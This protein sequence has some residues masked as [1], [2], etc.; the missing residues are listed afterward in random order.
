MIGWVLAFGLLLCGL[1][2]ILFVLS[3]IKDLWTQSFLPLFYDAAQ[4]QNSIRRQHFAAHIEHEIWRL[5]LKEEWKDYRFAELEAEVDAEGRHTVFGILPFFKRTR[6]G[7]R[8]EK[9]LSKALRKSQERLILV[10]GEPGSGKS[11]ALRHVAQV[12]AASA[13]R[14][15]STKSI[16]PLYINLKELERPEGTAVDRKLIE[17]F[18]LKSLKRF[19][20]RDVDQFLDDKFQGGIKDG[21]WFFLFDSFDELPEVLSSTEVDA[22]IKSYGDAID[23]F[24]H[25]MNQCRGII[26]S[27]LFRGPNYFGWPRFQILPL[28]E[29]RRLQLIRKADLTSERAN[30]FIGQL[31]NA[32]L[33][34]H[35]MASNPLFLNLLCEY[36]KSGRPF[37]ENTHTVFEN[38]INTRLT[39]DEERVQRRFT[40]NT[41]Q[42][43]E[44]AEHIA[45]CMAADRGLGLNPTC[46]SI[47]SALVHLDMELDGNIDTYLEA[48]AFIKL[49]RFE[50]AVNSTQVRTFTF[51][52]RRFQEYFATCVVLRES[53]R[54]SPMQLLTDARWRETAV[55][56][57]QT[58][59]IEGLVKVI[60]EA[61][62]LLEESCSTIP[63]LIDS[64][65]EYVLTKDRGDINE[66]QG[67]KD[68]KEIDN[69]QTT[70]N[71]FSWPSGSL[72]LLSL[73]QDGF[74]SRLIDLPENIKLY[75]SKLIL[76]ATITGVLFDRKWALEVSG[77]VPKTVLTYL[78]N[79]AFSSQSEWLKEVA[80]RQVARLSNITPV[81]AQGIRD[82]ILDLAATK[83]LHREQL[84]T[85]AHLARIE[86]SSQYLATIKLLLWLPY[87]DLMLYIILSIVIFVLL[88]HYG[89]IAVIITLP[90]W[91]LLY[92][93]HLSLWSFMGPYRS[94]RSIYYLIRPFRSRGISSDAIPNSV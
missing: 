11:I 57:C 15:K 13:K 52:H 91:I 28:S 48:L 40:L 84:A 55:A 64:P 90:L 56:M 89:L 8:R 70:R 26:A 93:S 82:A 41:T 36:V 10:E 22:V 2:A 51:A 50:D 46:E 77:I 42:L 14:S 54:V 87:I 31:G 12:M 80:Y 83:R 9:T 73:L 4:R 47:Q 65:V 71:I 62:R 1:W 5:G 38:Y 58:Q 29:S 61:N 34:I 85:T 17:D 69:K 78:L 92:L 81:I 7:R 35:S 20:D 63:S 75:A 21:T 30:E 60:E 53:N 88:L 27:R 45:F 24:L 37:P 39:R 59:P 32:R 79:D 19:N 67:T 66:V 72:H 18:I 6:S 74:I 25:G 23:A 43:R 49:A 76:T 68:Q 86:R 33:E 94:F 44:T 3:K 16:I